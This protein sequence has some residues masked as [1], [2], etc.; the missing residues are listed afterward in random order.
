MVRVQ[1]GDTTKR[2]FFY[3][4]GDLRDGGLYTVQLARALDP[5]RPFYAVHP[6]GTDGTAVPDTLE[7]I[8]ADRLAA[9]RAVQPHGPYL[10]G[11][12]CAGA[13]VAFEMAQQ[14][15]EQGEQVDALAMVEQDLAH[16]E[17]RIARA[18]IG[19]WGTPRPPRHR[20]AT[21]LFLRLRRWSMARSLGGRRRPIGS[22]RSRRPIPSLKKGLENSPVLLRR[23]ARQ[24]Q[25]S[26]T[27]PTDDRGYARSRRTFE[28]ECR[29][30][31]AISTY[32]PRRY[33]GRVAM[34]WASR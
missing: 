7:E 23:D 31:W 27:L 4:H 19:L 34:F 1:A 18:L 29:Y 2:P 11:G 13:F 15:R 8:A 32:A 6:A 30:M 3:L 20:E 25:A 5:D 9:L 28:L 10:L 24:T 17:T 33:R 22:R 21:A 16:I 14:L 12:F 26:P